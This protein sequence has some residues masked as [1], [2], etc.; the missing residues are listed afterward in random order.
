MLTLGIIELLNGT[1]FGVLDVSYPI[2]GDFFTQKAARFQG[3]HVNPSRSHDN[4]RSRPKNWRRHSRASFGV[5][6]AVDH[7]LAYSWRME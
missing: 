4:E 1:K 5:G 7:V 3:R 6:D 2:D